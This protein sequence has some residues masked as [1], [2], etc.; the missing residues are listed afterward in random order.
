MCLYCM[1]V[2]SIGFGVS[3]SFG[4]GIDM[5]SIAETKLKIL[6]VLHHIKHNTIVSV[7]Q[8]SAMY[9]HK[10]NILKSSWPTSQ[11]RDRPRL[12]HPSHLHLQTEVGTK[13]KWDGNLAPT[14]NKWYIT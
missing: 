13:P 7:T 9:L 12:W 10:K 5:S 4:G 6:D 8:N 3:I 2:P 11:K 1:C 14:R